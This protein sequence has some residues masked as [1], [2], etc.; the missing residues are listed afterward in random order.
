MNSSMMQ[1]YNIE[2][3]SKRLPW[4]SVSYLKAGKGSPSL[5]LIHGAGNN[6][7]V[8]M[9]VFPYLA[10]IATTIAV[11]LPGHGNSAYRSIKGMDDYT[12]CIIDFIEALGVNRP[13][14]VGHS[15]GGAVSIKTAARYG[16][17]GG[18]ILV[19]TGAH[20]KVNPRLLKMFEEDFPGAV[21]TMT[22]WSFLRGVSGSLIDKVKEMLYLAGQ[23]VLLQDMK[24][25]D[26]YSGE[27]DL[28]RINIPTLIICG[29]EDVMTPVPLSMEL[30]VKIKG[31]K[32]SLI[33]GSGHMVQLEK[34][35]ELGRTIVLFIRELL[36]EY[37]GK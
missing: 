28:E 12:Q 14:L 29:K 32:I 27:A 31:S 21:D 33:D 25:C 24:A 15:M 2:R 20:L 37:G 22:K 4:G 30:H 34:S 35:G 18:L 5:I 19:G 7:E 16:N 23:E 11:D 9:D 8:W 3:F 17:L 1:F 26:G 6:A 13:V 36:G 10:D